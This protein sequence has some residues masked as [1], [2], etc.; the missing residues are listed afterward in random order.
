MESFRE[1]CY[2]QQEVII[3]LNLDGTVRVR[4]MIGEGQKLSEY[5]QEP[6]QRP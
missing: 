5:N 1:A 3:E 4:Q 2:S 6:P